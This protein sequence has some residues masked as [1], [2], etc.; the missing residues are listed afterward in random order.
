MKYKLFLFVYLLALF[1]S[2]LK[3]NEV[4]S[5]ISTPLSKLRPTQPAIGYDQ[6]IYKLGRY[7]FD[8]KKKFDEICEAFGQKGIKTFSD[9]STPG[10]PASFTCK[11]PVGE[12]K[13]EMKT[14]VIAPDDELYLTDGHHTFNAFTHMHGGGADFN[15][16]VV[17]DK[18]YRH[19]KS[20]AQFWQSMKDDKQVWLNDPQNR[21]ITPNDLPKSLGMQNFDNDPYRALM[22]FSR[23]VSWDKPEQPIPFLEFYWAKEL[24]KLTSTAHYDL[25]SL[26]GYKAAIKNVSHDLLSINTRDIG[27]SGNTGEDMGQYQEIKNKGLDKVSKPRGKL[28]YMIQFKASP[29]GRQLLNMIEKT[30]KAKS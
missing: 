17:V 25:L 9:H 21:A 11:K 27:G 3:A 2:S 20:M 18:D 22:Y 29:E 1:C 28:S 30:R 23:G 14:V 16:Y 24:N 4:G 7:Q 6:V 19:L 15:V 12:I 8:R 10:N 5:I 13:K 26:A